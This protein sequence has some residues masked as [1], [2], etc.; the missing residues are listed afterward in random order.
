RFWHQARRLPTGSV[1][2]NRT[3]CARRFR[4]SGK[5]KPRCLRL[6]RLGRPRCLRPLPLTRLAFSYVAIPDLK[7]HPPPS[8]GFLESISFELVD[9]CQRLAGQLTTSLHGKSRTQGYFAWGCF[10]KIRPTVLIPTRVALRKV[11]Q[12]NPD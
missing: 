7:T 11:V 12:A 9:I 3:A 8:C 4:Y 2:L 5:S 6:L 1:G 10:A